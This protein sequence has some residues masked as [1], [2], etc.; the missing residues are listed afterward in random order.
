MR[1]CPVKHIDS[2]VFKLNLPQTCAKCHS[3]QKLTAEYRI[4]NSHA[5]A[6]YLDSIHGQALLKM[7]LIVAPSCNDC[8]GVHD[9]KR[10]VDESSRTNH[11]NIANDLR[12][13]PRRDRGGLQPERARAV[14]LAKG[15]RAARS[16]RTATPPTRS[17][18]PPTST[19]R[20]PATRCAAAATR[21][22]SPTTAK[23][24]MARRWRSGGRTWPPTSP[25]ATTA[26]ATTMSSR[27]ATRAPACRR[28]ASS[29]PASS[30][31]PASASKFTEYRP[32]ADPLDAV[33]YPLL[34]KVFSGMTGAAHRRLRF[35][36]PAH[37]LLARP[38]GLPVPARLEDIPG[39]QGRGDSGRRA[40]HA[41]HLL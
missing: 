27:S 16:A 34:H 39:G 10:S 9:I 13:V 11:A 6:N 1:S 20:R 28:S 21:T 30:A 14:L 35:L 40:V 22:G 12:A 8:H 29:R 7:G 4:G 33:H 25:P 23:P 32:H 17:R 2:P 31:T 41:F 5:A 26:T 3:N 38:L 36:R 18:T 15:D 19:S 24:T 37:A